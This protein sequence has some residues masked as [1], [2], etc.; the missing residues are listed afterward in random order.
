[1]YPIEKWLTEEFVQIS[2][3][4]VDVTVLADKGDG[5]PVG[6]GTLPD[7]P[8]VAGNGDVRS[9]ERANRLDT[10]TNG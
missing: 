2:A 6:V 7:V 8:G 9:L 10:V 4:V 1:M 3:K 5:F